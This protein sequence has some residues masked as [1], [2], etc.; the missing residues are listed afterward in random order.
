MLSMDKNRG[1][2]EASFGIHQA[3]RGKRVNIVNF[4]DNCV[5]KRARNEPTKHHQR[6]KID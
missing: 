3:A 2:L 6:S 4:E 5:A 1:Q